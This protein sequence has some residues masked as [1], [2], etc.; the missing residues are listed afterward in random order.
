MKILLNKSVSF[1]GKILDMIHR[2]TL[3]ALGLNVYAYKVS[4]SSFFKLEN[5]SI[6]KEMVYLYSQAYLITNVWN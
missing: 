5:D 3:S 2:L 6:P 1:A 4:E